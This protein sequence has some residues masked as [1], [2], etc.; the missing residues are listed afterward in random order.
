MQKTVIRRNGSL[1]YRLDLEG[2]VENAWGV[3]YFAEIE[4]LAPNETKQLKLLV[5]GMPTFSKPTVEVEEN[6]H[7]KYCLQ[8]G[9]ITSHF[10]LFSRV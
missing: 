3:S 6:A 4:D 9:Y 10:H 1:N 7:G 8:P 2:F 5:L